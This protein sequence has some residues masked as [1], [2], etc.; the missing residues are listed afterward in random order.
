MDAFKAEAAIPTIK[1][2]KHVKGIRVDSKFKVTGP[3]RFVKAYHESGHC[4]FASLDETAKISLGK[5]IL[6]AR[7]CAERI[8]KKLKRQLNLENH[9][10][11]GLAN[12]TI[13]ACITLMCVLAVIIASYKAGKPKKLEA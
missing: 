9:H 4:R 2:D 6:V 7:L 12:V 8:F 3:K 1:G 5:E 13:H 10:Y 11:R